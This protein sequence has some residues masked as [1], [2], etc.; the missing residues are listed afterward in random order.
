MLCYALF[1]GM[2]AFIDVPHFESVGHLQRPTNQ[3]LIRYGKICKDQYSA[4]I[5][6]FAENKYQ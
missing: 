4:Q 3:Y 1:V 2:T 6:A 5:D